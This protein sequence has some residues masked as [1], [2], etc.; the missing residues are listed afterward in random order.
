MFRLGEQTLYLTLFQQKIS[1]KKLKSI[2]FSTVKQKKYITV[3]QD[4]PLNEIRLNF[5]KGSVLHADYFDMFLLPFFL[6]TVFQC[7]RLL[8]LQK[9]EVDPSTN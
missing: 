4:I 8:F 2:I 6:S 9:R 3:C 5:V 7:L 1:K